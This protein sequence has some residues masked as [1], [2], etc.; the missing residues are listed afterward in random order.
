MSCFKSYIFLIACFL[1]VLYL[2][3][4]GYAIANGWWAIF[5]P[6]LVLFALHFYWIWRRIRH[7]RL[8]MDVFTDILMKNLESR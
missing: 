4:G 3:V 8:T 1:P 5:V 2:L 7:D 6:Y